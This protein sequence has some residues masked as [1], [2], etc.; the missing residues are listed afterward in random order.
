MAEEAEWRWV[1]K[2]LSKPSLQLY[3]D[4]LWKLRQ[5]C[6]AKEKNNDVVIVQINRIDENKPTNI[7]YNV[8]T[9]SEYLNEWHGNINGHKSTNATNKLS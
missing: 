3:A 1:W 9:A 5:C 4:D 2:S 6:S 8:A 7:A